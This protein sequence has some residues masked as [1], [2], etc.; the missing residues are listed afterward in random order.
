V[1]TAE[2]EEIFRILDLVREEQADGLKRLLASIH[3]VA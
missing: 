1:V 3:V 2:D